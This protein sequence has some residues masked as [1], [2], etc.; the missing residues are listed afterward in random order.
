MSKRYTMNNSRRKSMRLAADPCLGFYMLPT[1]NSPDITPPVP[2]IPPIEVLMSDD[3]CLS[4]TDNAEPMVSVDAFL[5]RTTHART[6][7]YGK[8][9]KRLRVDDSVDLEETDE[10]PCEAETPP[11]RLGLS[12][13][14]IRR[15]FKPLKKRLLYAAVLSHA[16]P[17][18]WLQQDDPLP[19]ARKPLPLVE[20]Q[21]PPREPVQTKRR[22]WSLVDPRK[23][24]LIRPNSFSGRGKA[25][26]S[27]KTNTLSGWRATYG[28]IDGATISKRKTEA[29]VASRA[30]MKCPPLSFVSLHEAEK[31]YSLMR[32]PRNKTEAETPHRD[33][34]VQSNR[35]PLKLTSVEH[36]SSPTVCI[37]TKTTSMES[38]RRTPPLAFTSASLDPLPTALEH[39]TCPTF[40]ASA[41]NLMPAAIPEPTSSPVSALVHCDDP[42]AS[43][44]RSPPQ[45]TNSALKPLASFFDQFLQTA[46]A[47]TQLEQTKKKVPHK[48]QHRNQAIP[49]PQPV[50]TLKSFLRNTVRN[51]SSVH[52]YQNHRLS[53]SYSSHADTSNVPAFGVPPS[54][55]TQFRPPSSP[56]ARR[57][58]QPTPY[59]V[60][61]PSTPPTTGQPE[62]Y[63]TDAN[64][65]DFVD[66]S[67]NLFCF[68]TRARVC[69][70]FDRSL[71]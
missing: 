62:S 3:P 47:E 64:D 41:G 31:S 16:E 8:K 19:P 69:A 59:Q 11:S 50:G 57:A 67:I 70:S 66:S 52:R 26:L 39:D 29:S 30:S 61:L 36:H 17:E 42:P 49:P 51:N 2:D 40:N 28:Q 58:F 43:P 5:R 38:S 6:K 46:R 68:H 65:P 60:V 48:N 44:A 9:R 24:V 53:P 55:T 54:M 23:T 56:D 12:A 35:I 14:P 27:A 21:H 7:L 10:K 63:T 45:S 1:S 25:P 37:A 13:K 18:E 32:L 34:A 22:T 33:L 4:D 20:Q 71:L 15:Q